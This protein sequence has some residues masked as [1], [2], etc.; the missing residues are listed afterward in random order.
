MSQAQ[1]QKTIPLVTLPEDYPLRTGPFLAEMYEKHGPIFRA[2][3]Y[4][5]EI[6]YLVGPEA[7]R[8]VLVSNR[9]KFSHHEGWGRLFGVVDM[10]GDGLLTMDGKEHDQHRRMMN[11]AFSVGETCV[12]A[13]CYS[14]IQHIPLFPCQP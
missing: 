2:S 1:T 12:V 14:G 4:G 8:F 13:L 5:G 7:N 10:F 11:P 6:I 9:Q 3:V